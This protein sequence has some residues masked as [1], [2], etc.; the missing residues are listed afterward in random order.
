MFPG[1]RKTR[2]HEVRGMLSE[3][4]DNRLD[5][6]VRGVVERHLEICAACSNELESLQMTVRLLHQVPE[7]PT[8]RSFAVREADVVRERVP[9]K[10]RRWGQLRPVPAVA[11]SEVETGGVSI[12]DPQRLRWLRAAT[13]FATVALIAL[14]MVDFLQVVPHDVGTGGEKVL[15]EPPAQGMLSATP[16]GEAY[17]TESRSDETAVPLPAP[18]PPLAEE[19]PTE[20]AGSYGLGLGVT[21]NGR[22]E[23]S[24][25]STGGWPLRQI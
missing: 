4:I 24:G 14:L 13:A 12:F 21:Y 2:C 11:T 6:E 15:M 1:G 7:M 22:E 17:I 5:S 3:Y 20:D 18:V 10:A 23:I 25:E 9:T 8:P 19:A 16:E